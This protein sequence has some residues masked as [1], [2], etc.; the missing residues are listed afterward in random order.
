M[1][2]FIGYYESPIGLIEII[3]DEHFL[4]ELW[5]VDKIQETTVQ[6]EILKKTLIQLDE[7]FKGGRVKFELDCVL[8]GTEFQKSVWNALSEIPYGSLVSYKDVAD[9]I[10]SP[11]ACRAVGNANNKNKIGIVIP[12]HRVIGA[13]QSLTGYVGGL[14][15]KQWLIDHERKHKK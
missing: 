15:R 2:K 10:N 5:F 8:E 7:Y 6:P 12:C 4:R 1:S 9:S 13:N 14:D 3:T 11:K